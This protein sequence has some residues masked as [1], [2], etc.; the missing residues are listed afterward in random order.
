[1]LEYAE[2]YFTLSK[3]DKSGKTRLETLIEI[4]QQTGIVAPELR[5]VL[6]LPAET[7][8]LWGWFLDLSRARGAGMQLESISWADMDAYLTRMKLD[9]QRWEI[10]AVRGLD[11]A[12]LK[13]RADNV[14]A[15]AGGAK[16]LKSRMTGKR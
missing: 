10:H 5:D 8:Y 6:E 1:M 15:K 7:A 3:P 4:R 14:S 2:A 13:S 12:F 11:E 16:A 9:P